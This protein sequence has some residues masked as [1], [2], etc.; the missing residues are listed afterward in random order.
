MYKINVHN[1]KVY[2]NHGCL[3]E[4]AIIGGEYRVDVSVWFDYTNA[5]LTDDLS[6]TADYVLIK[7]LVY[8]EMAIRAKLIET[9]A[10]RLYTAIKTEIPDV[11]KAWVR[12]T[13]INAPTGGQ[14]ES[15]SVE[16]EK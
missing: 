14:V 8:R 9:V 10:H 2:A 11:T 16:I 4:E 6:L 15:V 13:K 12:I 3:D 7:E 5:A 1:I